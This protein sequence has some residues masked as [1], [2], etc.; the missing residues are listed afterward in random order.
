MEIIKCIKRLRHKKYSVFSKTLFTRVIE[1]SF[2]WYKIYI[3]VLVSGVYCM[4]AYSFC[5]FISY[6]YETSF[7][8]IKSLTWCKRT[9][10]ENTSWRT[11]DSNFHV[12]KNE[13]FGWCVVFNAKSI[14]GMQRWLILYLLSWCANNIL[15]VKMTKQN[16]NVNIYTYISKSCII[17]YI[18]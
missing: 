6:I 9:V 15:A 16:G 3:C 5:T 13:I 11:I 2:D 14:F 7:F 10:V 17:I 1:I 8:V 4:T 18:K 12:L